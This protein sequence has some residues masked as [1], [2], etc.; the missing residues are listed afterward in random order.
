MKNT[1]PLLLL[2][3]MLMAFTF[4]SKAQDFQPL[5]KSPHDIAYYRKTNLMP[6]L[7]KVLY[8]RPQK[9]GREIFGNV[10][11]YGKV[12]RVGANEST[13]VTFYEDVLFG[14]EKI[15][16]GIYT[17]F[18]IPESSE[19]TIILSSNLDSWGTYEYDAK[20]DV[21][22][23]KSKVKKAEEL[24]SFSIGFKEKGQAVEMVLGWDTTRVSVPITTN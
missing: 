1:Y 7:V 10:V 16:K 2:G 20:Q 23:V 4:Q 19:W 5:D 21:A 24:E 22:R 15:K 11:P 3:F 8:G 9:S 13:E 6:P 18:A 12:W 17:L 14:S